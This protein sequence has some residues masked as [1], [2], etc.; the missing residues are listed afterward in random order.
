MKLLALLPTSSFLTSPD[1][2]ETTV[3]GLCHAM[4]D[5]DIDDKIADHLQVTIGRTHVY[6]TY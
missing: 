3:S 5:L 6:R 1:D 4:I 2:D